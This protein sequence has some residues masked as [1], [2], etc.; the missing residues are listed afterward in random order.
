MVD[1]KLMGPIRE[2]KWSRERGWCGGR[3]KVSFY[4]VQEDTLAL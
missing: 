1:S 4:E 3:L 2:K